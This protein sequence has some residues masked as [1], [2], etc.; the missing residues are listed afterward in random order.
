MLKLVLLVAFVICSV[1]L[2]PIEANVKGAVS[3]DVYNFDRVISRF[4]T[5]LV[6]FD[7]VYP[8]GDKHEAFNTVA[9]ELKDS[10][11]I[12]FVQIGIKDYGEYDN[13][14]LAER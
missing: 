5:V 3:L 10:D 7:A 6:K 11:E 12:L 8:F 2:A 14:E 1:V 4:D 9:E 13:Q